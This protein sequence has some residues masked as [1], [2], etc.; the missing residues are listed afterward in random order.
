MTDKETYPMTVESIPRFIA[1]IPGSLFWR[2]R[3]GEKAIEILGDTGT[4]G[5]GYDAG[6]LLRDL[7]WAQEMVV[8]DDF[9]R[10]KLFVQAVREGKEASVFFRIR[11]TGA[12]PGR[13]WL[14]IT[15]AP[16]GGTSPYYYGWILDMTRDIDFINRLLEKDLERQTKIESE[17]IPVLLVDMGTK[18]VISRSTFAYDLFGYTF[19]EFNDVKFRDLYPPEAEP[20]MLRA[21][22]ACL[23]EGRWEGELTLV[24]KDGVSFNAGVKLKRLSV[25]DRDLL[26]MSFHSIRG[27]T[28]GERDVPAASPDLL[29]AMEGKDE[30]EE[31]LDTL[32]SHEQADSLFDGVTYVDVHARKGRVDIY[33]RGEPFRNFK[34][35]I[36]Y[37]YEGTVSQMVREDRLE[38]FILR[39]TLESTRPIDWALFI[40]HGIRSYFGRTFFHGTRLRTL[41]IFCSTEPNRFTEADI[42]IFEPYY[43]AFLQGLR[44]WRKKKR[45]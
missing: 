11:E 35:G 25:R 14:K 29:A 38:F 42:E 8:E 15:G 27:E 36:S 33:G 34:S 3:N 43:S 31:I 41:L 40:P 6:K 37:E 20:G 13:R 12:T 9:P 2:K 10:F 21:Y 39:D 19:H 32:L 30:M 44:N 18:S 23:L 4:A 45:G 17:D 7:V 22:D 26:K 28:S 1:G 5:P 16:F 24:K